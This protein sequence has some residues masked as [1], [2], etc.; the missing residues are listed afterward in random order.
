MHANLQIEDQT[1]GDDELFD[2]AAAEYA[3]QNPQEAKLAATKSSPFV[4]KSKQYTSRR[5]KQLTDTNQT[6]GT[7]KSDGSSPNDL[8]K[9]RSNKQPANTG[10]MN[11]LVADLSETEAVGRRHKKAAD[12][13]KRSGGKAAAKPGDAAAS[14]HDD[15]SHLAEP[16][17]LGQSSGKK[18][19]VVDRSNSAQAAAVGGVFDEIFDDETVESE[20]RIGKNKKRKTSPSPVP[21]RQQSKRVAAAAAAAATAACAAAESESSS[22]E[23]EYDD[24]G[25]AELSNVGE[26]NAEFTH[27]DDFQTGEISDDKEEGSNDD[28]DEDEDIDALSNVSDEQEQIAVGLPEQDL[29][30]FIEDMLDEDASQ[31][32]EN[33]DGV[34]DPIDGVGHSIALHA[35]I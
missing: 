35:T 3:H 8:T 22:S 1:A 15:V 31:D 18:Q 29:S 4:A 7:L 33:H 16:S 6:Q 28:D 5:N 25:Q 27:T 13:N 21:R 17:A 9:S 23:D 26:F 11:A 30:S 34:C 2:K 10:K 19:P 32:P 24:D 12:D 20:D 14:K